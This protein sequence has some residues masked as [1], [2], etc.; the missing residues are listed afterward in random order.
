MKTP[1]AK[2]MSA[3]K[4]KPNPGELTCEE[5]LAEAIVERDAASAACMELI[6]V[7]DGL[8]SQLRKRDSIGQ[9]IAEKARLRVARIRRGK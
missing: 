6:A 2:P 1:G 5:R 7:A 3:K 9:D 4:D 8:I